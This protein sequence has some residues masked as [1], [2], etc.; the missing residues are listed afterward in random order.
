METIV[1][2]LRGIQQPNATPVRTNNRAW[3]NRQYRSARECKARI[4]M[5]NIP[6]Q[7]VI[8]TPN[9]SGIVHGPCGKLP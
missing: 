3:W 5:P 1:D 4:I 2:R 7:S 9:K 6:S 8:W